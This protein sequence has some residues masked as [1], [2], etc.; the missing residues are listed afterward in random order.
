MVQAMN[1]AA[2]PTLGPSLLGLLGWTAAF[3]GIGVRRFNRRYA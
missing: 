2:A 1:G 3:F